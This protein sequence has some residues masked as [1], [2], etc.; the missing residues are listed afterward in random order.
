MN[1][2]STITF[3]PSTQGMSIRLVFSVFRVGD[4]ATLKIYDGEDITRDLIATYDQY[5]SPLGIDIV[6]TVNNPTGALTVAFTSGSSVKE[7]WAASISCHAPCQPYTIT[8]DEV[9]SS[10]PWVDDEY[11]NVCRNEEVT[12]CATGNYPNNGLLYEQS[13]DNVTFSWQ[14]TSDET[15]HTGQCITKVFD[16]AHGYTFYLTAHDSQN[17]YPSSIIKGKVRVSDNMVQSI[18][19]LPDVCSG[20]EFPLVIDT[21]GTGQIVIDPI[22][23]FTSATLNVADQTFL[24]DGSGVSYT[25]ELTYTVFEPGQTLSSINDLFGICFDMEH[26]YLGDLSIRI[27]CPSGQ[28]CLLKSRNA[29]ESVPGGVATSGSYDGGDIHLGFAP[30]PASYNACYE[31]PGQPLTYCFTPQSTTPMGNNGPTTRITYTDPCGNRETY[32][33]LNAG[34]YGSYENMSVLLGCQLNGAWK[35]TVTDH[36]SQDNGYI[37]SWGLSLNPDLIPGGWGYEVDLDTVYWS[38]D[39]FIPNPESDHAFEGTVIADEPGTF[40]YQITIVDNLGC[41]YTEN[42]P[43]TV[44][45]TPEPNLPESMK[46]CP[47]SQY[48]TLDP[49]VNYIGS[50]AL[51]SYLWRTGQT[52]S[53]IDVTDT[54]YYYLTVTTFNTD[55]SLSCMANDTIHIGVSPMPVADFDA[56]RLADCTPLSVM[57]RPHCSFVDGEA[58]PELNLYYDWTILDENNAIVFTS[59]EES[60]HL[61]LTTKGKYTVKL[62]VRTENGCSDSMTRFDYLTVFPQPK[63]S[64]DYKIASYG[65]EDGGICNFVNTTDLSNFNTIDDVEWHWNFGDGQESTDF[66]GPHEYA[67]SGLYTVTLD[68]FTSTGCYDQTSNTIRIPSPYYF[69]IPNSF[70]PNEDGKNDIFKPYGYGMNPEKYEMSIF[71]RTGRMVFHTDNYEQGWNGMDNGKPAPFGAYAYVIK[72]ERMDGEKKEYTGTVT[73]IR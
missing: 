36:L 21:N 15:P 72:T 27:T 39:N 53:T 23:D 10:K 55:H 54:G 2:N 58:H 1:Q 64:F 63:A 41:E 67:N 45:H 68:I 9:H 4:G 17:C 20:T 61:S 11:F 7:G 18:A 24:P 29:S 3:R 16:E 6:A 19:A 13:D 5:I 34:N 30:D 73:V 48:A 26:S 71:E 22:S 35:I 49:N 42:I 37:F 43:L 8:F 57:L 56:N 44:I 31:T 32:S 25:S 12:F 46:I 50:P 40:N 60:P 14:F 69:Y 38:S 70:T 51:I 33:Q 62:A 66:D 47:G 52:T 65:V 28:S 59:S